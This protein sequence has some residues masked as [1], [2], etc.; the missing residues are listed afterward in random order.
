MP[1]IIFHHVFKRLIISIRTSQMPKLLTKPR[2]LVLYLLPVG[3]A[4]LAP[5]DNKK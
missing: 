1:G 5:T 2:I 3:L 4:F